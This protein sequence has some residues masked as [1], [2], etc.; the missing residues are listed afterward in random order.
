MKQ[1]FALSVATV[2][3]LTMVGAPAA[4][5]QDEAA[6]DEA[7]PAEESGMPPGLP[8]RDVLAR[9]RCRREFDW[10]IY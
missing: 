2:V 1:R 4:F 5:A 9:M 8:T 10:H 3:A 6:T 7:A